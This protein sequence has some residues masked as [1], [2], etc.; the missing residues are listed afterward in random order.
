MSPRK[1]S[2]HD[3]PLAPLA[4]P[5]LHQRVVALHERVLPREAR[6]IYAR[7]LRGDN[8]HALR[9]FGKTARAYHLF[10][11]AAKLLA[12]AIECGLDGA[13]V[14][15]ELG[16]ALMSA[17]R[18][19]EAK[20]RF[21]EAAALDPH[22][23]HCLVNLATICKEEGELDEAAA[24][25]ERAIV[26]EP[27]Y[28]N[29]HSNLAEVQLLQGE[30]ERTLASLDAALDHKPQCTWSLALRSI[31]LS[32]R[33]A[34]DDFRELMR[35]GELPRCIPAA[36]P[37]GFHDLDEFNQRLRKHIA[38]HR[39]LVRDPEGLSTHHG[40]HTLGNLLS[41]RA[42]VIVAM[43]ELIHAALE[44]YVAALPVDPGHPFLRERPE[45]TRL[46]G[47]GV[48]LER[49]GF[50]EAHVHRD[51]WLSGVYYV[52]LG[53]IV[54]QDDPAHEGWLQLGQGPATLY[55]R[56]S[57]PETQLVLP[58]EGNFV[59]FPAYFWHRTLPFSRDRER[60]AFAFDVIPAH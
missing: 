60:V 15:N 44:D 14:H 50:H 30:P 57:T 19:E 52:S 37:R 29:A 53:G 59:L 2:R 16:V 49:Q 11:V 20:A 35:F 18:R 28:A 31:A 39:T 32:E 10:D 13:D 55:P 42:P 41:D 5:Q 23:A 7:I 3:R 45:A 9:L 22:D 12:K 33:E 58:E 51:G 4:Y 34:H 17:G 1:R 56:C 26:L 38:S 6:K 40:W 48:K 54:R 46:E 43:T 27:G 47:W 8:P 36:P 24:T 25:L 21:L